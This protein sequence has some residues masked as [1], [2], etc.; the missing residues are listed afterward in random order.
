M[1]SNTMYIITNDHNL[2]E[3]SE[4]NEIDFFTIGIKAWKV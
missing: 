4:I 3:F 2:T 1:I